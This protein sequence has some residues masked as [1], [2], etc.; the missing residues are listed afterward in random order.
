MLMCAEQTKK[1]KIHV[2]TIAPKPK[3]DVL[4]WADISGDKQTNRTCTFLEVKLTG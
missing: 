2:G 1:Q 4:G 3:K